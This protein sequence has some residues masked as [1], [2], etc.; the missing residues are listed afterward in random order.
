MKSTATIRSEL[1]KPALASLFRLR[2]QLRAYP[3]ASE[4]AFCRVCR[5]LSQ[6]AVWGGAD[7]EYLPVDCE[8]EIQAIRLRFFLTVK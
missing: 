5:N 1:L 7:K 3:G 4:E 2:V 6:L 8:E